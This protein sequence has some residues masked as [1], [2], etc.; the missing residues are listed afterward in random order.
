MHYQRPDRAFNWNWWFGLYGGKDTRG[1]QFWQKTIDRWRGEGLP[2][3]VN[4]PK[5]V[6]DFFGVDRCMYLRLRNGVWPT[7]EPEVLEETEEFQVTYDYDGNVIKQFKGADVETS[8]PLYLRRPV[9]SREEWK[10]YARERLDP[11]ASGRGGFTIR[12]D[13][14]TLIESAPDAPNFEEARR[15]LIESSLP[16]EVNA[17]SMYGW[18]RNWMGT[19]GL[20]YALYDDEALVA[21]MMERTAD[22]AISVIERV[23]DPLDVRIDH[24]A[25]WE[26]MA[27]KGGPLI[28]PKHI[29]RL[30]VPQYRRVNDG[31]R[32][33]GI[34]VIGVDSDG[35]VDLIIPHWL[36]AGI[37]CVFPNEA[38]AGNDVVA[39]R[40]K[41]GRDLLLIGGIDK[42][43]L[44]K[45]KEAIDKELGRRLPLVAE[46][47]YLPAVDHSVPPDISFQDYVYY[48][49]VQAAECARY[50][51]EWRA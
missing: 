2:A 16:V 13:G 50:L 43:A 10:A 11:N 29:E 38:A 20:S 21:E 39:M 30:M 41:Y 31:L 5:L 18:M 19:K 51:E 12:A 46:G 24:A 32:K 25:W 27:H 33:R 49:D 17:V 42:R 14:V 37:N 35:N 45:G 44:A 23:L 8:M 47:G 40:R 3:E 7:F 28:S 48:S 22:V 15:L 6:N 1:T 9:T 26:D 34:D 36:D 4:T